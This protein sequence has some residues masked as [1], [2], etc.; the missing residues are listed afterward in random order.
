MTGKKGKAKK[1]Y[2]LEN[3]AAR[4]GGEPK[5]EGGGYRSLVGSHFGAL[6]YIELPRGH[7]DIKADMYDL[8]PKVNGGLTFHEGRVFGWDYS[9]A[10]NDYNIPQ[11]IRNALRYF[12]K[13]EKREGDKDA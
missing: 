5:D 7:P 8:T 9:H 12:R 6:A 1:E 3:R 13:R 10:W 11:H 2:T 4:I